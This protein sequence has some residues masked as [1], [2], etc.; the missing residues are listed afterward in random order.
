MPESS[1][2][3]PPIDDINRTWFSSLRAGELRI[4]KCEGCGRL[5]HT[6]RP[7]CPWCNVLGHCWERMSGRGRIWSFIVAHAPVLPVFADRVP[8]PVAIVEIEEDPRIRIVGQLGENVD[9]EKVL[10]GASVHAVFEPVSDEMGL[11]RWNL[12]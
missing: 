12:A 7:M 11:I 5:R 4:Q 2:P 6:P 8:M 9:P 10:I 1:L 3:L